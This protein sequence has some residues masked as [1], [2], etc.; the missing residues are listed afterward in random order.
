MK[1]RFENIELFGQKLIL[2]ERIASDVHDFNDFVKSEFGN[3][4]INVIEHAVLCVDVIQDAL[5]ANIEQLKWFNF[6]KKRKYKK[7][8]SSQFLL[9]NL[10]VEKRNKLFMKIIE[11]LE[12]TEKISSKAKNKNSAEMCRDYQTC[13]VALHSNI[14]YDEAEQ[15][16]ITQFKSRFELAISF[17]AFKRGDKFDLLS[18]IDKMKALHR[19]LKLLHPELWN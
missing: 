18:S 19:D 11:D 6:I 5:K 16:P 3:K 13:L 2:H 12:L 7:I 17:S 10:S 4:K 1:I 9:K 8:L 15:L 14:S